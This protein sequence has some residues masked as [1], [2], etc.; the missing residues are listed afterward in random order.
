MILSSLLIANRGEIAIRV[1]RAAAELGLRTVAIYSDDDASSLHTRKSDEARALH[2]SGVAAYLDSARI[3]AVAKEAGCDAIHPGYGFLSENADFARLCADAGITF[4]G[5]RPDLLELFGD[6]VR[7]RQLAERCGVPVMPGT[8]GAASLDDAKEFFSSLGNGGAMMIKAVAGGGG[9]GIRAVNR[10]EEVEESYKRCQSEARAAFG[11]G[12]V[13]V[14]RMMPRARHVEVQIV[15]DN[16]G[17]LSHL[18][19]R[20]CSIQRRHQKLIEIAPSPGLPPALRDRLTAAAILL[21]KEARY[22]NLGTFEF[23]VDAGGRG[24]EPGF[25]FLEA[26]PRLQVEH[27]VT[28]AVTG[29]DIVRLQLQLA[30][31]LSLAELGVTQSDIPRP[32]GFA[33]QVRI[34]MESMAADGTAKPS[35]GTISGFEAPSGPGIRV[36][37]FAYSGYATNPSFD[38]LLAKLIVHS[39]SADFAD[40]VK[41]T[42][43]ALCEFKVEGVPTNIGFLQSLLRHRDF[44]ANNLYTRFVED[45]VAEL[46]VTAAHQRLFFD[47]A[48]GGQA[49]GA[50][51]AGIKLTSSDPLAVLN[52]GKS[53]AMSAADSEALT[54]ASVTAAPPRPHA[55]VG[56]EGTLEVQAPMQGTIVSVDVAEGDLVRIGQQLFVMEAM[57]MEH[58]VAANVAGVV[59]MITVTKGDAVFEGHP[60]A[61]I[62]QS[63]LQLTETSAT[64]EVALDH[65]RPDL[66]EVHERHEAGLDRSRPEAVARRRKTRQR[67]ARENISQLCDPGTFV[68]Y[69]PLVIA[70]QRR[71]RT[72]EDLIKN[73]PADGMVAG[74]GRVN[75]DLFEESRTQCVLMSYDYTVLAGTQGQQN[76]RKKDRMFEIAEN[77]RLPVVFFCEG[78]GGRPGDTDG[79]GVAGLD[80]MAFN[81]WGKLS[82]LVPL[83]GITSGRCFAGNAALLGCCDVVIA[84]KGSNIGMGGPA[85]IEGG[86][87]GIF[88]PEEVGPLE[89]QVA[90]GVV[91]IPVAD[92]VEAV[93]VVKKYVSYFQG[94]VSNWDCAD[95]RMLRGIIPENRLRIYDVRAVIETLAD[96]GS[97]LEMRRYFGLGMVTA[98][99][100]IEGR[101]VGVIANNPAHLA[102]AI[103]SDGA[104]KAARFMQL[105]D[106]FDIPILFLCDTPGIMVGPEVEKTALVRHAARMFVV[107]SNITVPFFTIILR[108]GYG[109]GAQAMAGGSFK[110]PFFTIAWPTG[111]FGG[112]GLEGAVKLG[113]RGEL[114]A[115]EDP[116]KRKE[117]F[118]EMVERMYRHGKAV[119][120]A[121]HFEIDDV[122]D[123]MESRRW[124]MSALRSAPPLAPR[125]G[126]KRPCIDPW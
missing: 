89:V 82:G 112:M 119:N 53:Q 25:T 13:Y 97:V 34:N 124:I 37:T 121:S 59:Q 85:M 61:F 6:K 21:A 15:A 18:W 3:I 42:Y 8:S 95:Q 11:N 5:P 55:L 105:C 123:P 57:K 27:T 120:T 64:R 88:R 78:G 91:D 74:I 22:Q 72:I 24:D 84:T 26:N 41:K 126:K 44:A 87:L 36:D 70:A 79:V 86:G 94:T 32:R 9:R 76:H 109:L 29:I 110:A 40:A 33:I 39:A 58:V 75:G 101:P 106:S 117:L 99:I 12:D 38:S 68:E 100:R 114:A 73:T 2:A 90:N 93:E 108:K 65:V 43:R 17:N 66:A 103:V 107:G 28:E 115:V 50:K 69:G 118:D 45:H 98:F 122:I 4:V 19:E 104:D 67:T 49:A 23:L 46:A 48:A 30:G 47:K 116:L 113:Y 35:G 16:A 56:P 77:S 7:S 125:S 20:E 52:H 81:Y 60:L 96:S 10:I 83:V 51:L 63:E 62:E 14:E 111:E 54:D 71:R 92:E 1:M 80:C 31:G 102:G